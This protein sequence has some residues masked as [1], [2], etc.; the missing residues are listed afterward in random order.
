MKMKKKGMVSILMIAILIGLLGNP[1]QAVDEINQ[2]KQNTATTQES[3]KQTT[4]QAS[5]TGKTKSNVVAEKSSNANLNDLGIRPHDFTGFKYGTTNYEVSVPES[6]ESVE[7]YATVQDA[8][9]KVTGTGKKVLEK[10]KNIAQVV[11]TAEDGTKK[12]YTIT[13]IREAQQEEQESKKDTETK[14]DTKKEEKGLAEL[15]IGNLNLTPEFKT[16]IYEYTVNYIGEDAKIEIETKPTEE[17]YVV[18]VVGNENL[19]EGENVITI[20]VS[21]KNGD[22]IATYQVTVN[23][24]L[25]DKEA[26]AKEVEK[27]EK[28]QKTI[29]GV[30]IAVIVLL[31]IIVVIVIRKRNRNIAEEFSGI[32]FYGNDEEEE[33]PKALEKEE[34]LD[35]ED[36]EENV[37]E[38]FENMSKD[39]LKEKFLNGYTSRNQ[40]RF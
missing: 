21:E 20:L 24:S 34:K 33:L 6:T 39:K 13:I 35:Q 28:Q 27:K 38:D 1:V 7:V 29:I 25:V 37:L 16:S 31:I 26:V 8:K 22:N 10:G 4:S 30:G 32:G 11:V 17:N 23:K 14:E 19:Q 18:E 40:Y 9:A 3:Q 15:K 5:N 12:T 2:T 36:L